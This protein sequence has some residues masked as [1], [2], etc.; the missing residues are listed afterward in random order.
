MTTPDKRLPTLW[1]T[2][3]ILSDWD[4]ERLACALRDADKVWID[5]FIKRLNY[6]VVDI[7]KMKI[8]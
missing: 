4:D 5:D 8:K 3:T 7:T 1:P 6:A 2:K